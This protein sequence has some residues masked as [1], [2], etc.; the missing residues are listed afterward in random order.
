MSPSVTQLTSCWRNLSRRNPEP[1]ASIS[2]L[3]L[4]SDGPAEVPQSEAQVN[5]QL[6]GDTSE[7]LS[8][9][10]TQLSIAAGAD[11]DWLVDGLR[12]GGSFDA[13][14]ALDTVL[15]DFDGDRDVDAADLL[16]MATRL[17]HVVRRVRSGRLEGPVRHLKRPLRPAKRSP[18]LKPPGL[19]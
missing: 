2:S 5:W 4:G 10:I 7:D 18:S 9:S 13:V 3:S 14:M 12:I 6:I 15:G 17:R 16:V 1:G 11:A 8:D 19:C